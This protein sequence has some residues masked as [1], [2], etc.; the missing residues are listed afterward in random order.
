MRKS[1][2]RLA[3]GVRGSLSRR[4]QLLISLRCLSRRREREFEPQ[5]TAF[6][7]PWGFPLLLDPAAPLPHPASAAPSVW[8]LVAVVLQCCG[9][10]ASHSSSLFQRHC[11][12]CHINCNNATHLQHILNLSSHSCI[13]TGPMDLPF[14]CQPLHMMFATVLGFE[15]GALYPAPWK[16]LVHQTSKSYKRWSVRQQRRRQ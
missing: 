6:N 10:H 11:P 16:S 3:A 15:H 2:Q 9:F 5:G 8:F 14:L 4:A 13:I 1:S 7:F 12:H